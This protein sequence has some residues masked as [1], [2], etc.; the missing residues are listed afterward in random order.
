MSI[1]LIPVAQ[2]IL[3]S[4]ISTFF[5]ILLSIFSNQAGNQEKLKVS[6]AILASFKKSLYGFP[7]LVLWFSL[8]LAAQLCYYNLIYLRR[9]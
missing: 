7:W 1:N 2:F 3:I 6:E 5:G 8:F 9:A 4:I